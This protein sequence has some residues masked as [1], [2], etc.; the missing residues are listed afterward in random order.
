MMR[1]IELLMAV[2][3]GRV[4][5]KRHRKWR[6]H[7]SDSNIESG[8]SDSDVASDARYS[9]DSQAP[10][11]H[12]SAL[13]PDDI[14]AS[15]PNR[16]NERGV[17]RWRFIFTGDSPSTKPDN[18][19]ASRAISKLNAIPHPTTATS[20]KGVLTKKPSTP[21]DKQQ[22]FES[23]RDLDANP[24]RQQVASLNGSKRQLPALIKYESPT[25]QQQELDMNTVSHVAASL[26]G[27]RRKLPGM[28]TLRE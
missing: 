3:T 21:L 7:G 22:F 17:G 11:M 5:P 2:G 8:Q 26:N 27:P 15:E 6:H 10:D 20:A 9:S 1:A 18:A 25:K 28:P 23:L 19:L 13:N 14:D 4:I 24:P 12:I 16:A